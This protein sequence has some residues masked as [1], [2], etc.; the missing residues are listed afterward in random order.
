MTIK[1]ERRGVKALVVGPL[2]EEL[3]FVAFLIETLKM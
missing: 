2:V 1:L 3:F